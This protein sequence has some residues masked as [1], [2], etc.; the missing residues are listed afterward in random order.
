MF[1]LC[2]F[3]GAADIKTLG[4]VC[5]CAGWKEMLKLII[6]IMIIGAAVS[7]CCILRNK[8]LIFRVKNIRRYIY[9]CIY[10]GKLL[11]YRE[12]FCECETG[13]IPFIPIIMAGYILY[14]FVRS[15]LR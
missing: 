3:F 6:C 13:T 10:A 9:E 12:I 11:N 7:L 14:K 4:I 5:A 1:W 15:Y 2:G 8:R